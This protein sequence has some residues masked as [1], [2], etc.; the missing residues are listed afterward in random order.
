MPV[1]NFF[2]ER[3]KSSSDQTVLFAALTGLREMLK[4]RGIEVFSEEDK[5]LIEKRKSDAPTAQVKSAAQDLQDDMAGRRSEL[6]TTAS[7]L[8]H[9]DINYFWHSDHFFF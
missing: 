2:I 3:L 4:I 8:F 9:T 6:N 1:Y 7:V 5:A